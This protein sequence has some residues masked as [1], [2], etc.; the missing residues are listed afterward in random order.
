MHTPKVSA[1]LIGFLAIVSIY[2]EANAQTPIRIENV[3]NTPENL[4]LSVNYR[5]RYETLNNRFRSGFTGSDQ[6]FLQRLL[7]AG[8][9]DFGG[10]YIGAELQDSRQQLADSG[11]PVG[12]DDVNTFELLKAYVGYRGDDVVLSGDNLDI[13]AGRVTLNISSRRLAARNRFRN[14]IN[15]FTGVQ[16]RWTAPGGGTLNSFYTLPVNRLP[17]DAESLLSND[18]QFDRER[19][20]QRFWGVHYTTPEFISELTAEFYVFGLQESDSNSLATRD[21]N[22]FTPGVRFYKSKSSGAIDFDFETTLQVGDAA[23]STAA[24]AERLNT[25]AH[26]HHVQLG[27][28]FENSWNTRV[29]VQ[30]D[31]AS[32]D[33]DPDDSRNGRFDTL[34]GARR[35]EFG[36]TGIFGA[37]ARSNINSPGARI[38]LAKGRW[39][40][41]IG[42]RAAYLASSRDA[43]TTAGLLD[44]TG[45]SGRFIGHQWETRVRYDVIRGNVQLEAGVAHLLEGEFLRT[46]PNASTDGDNFFT[47]SQISFSF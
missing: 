43:L 35:F 15:G 1:G 44:S 10:V 6:I 2:S 7:L 14:T 23:L 34:F 37:L 9:Y 22:L 27:Y 46:A 29:A 36:P 20:N 19:I 47:Y 24:D 12:T 41:L 38:E 17:N 28:T 8:E 13:A 33:R 21:R 3:L 31:F 16:V 26:F 45:A 18:V 4:S 5:V 11:T 30:Y 42:Y 25:I 40:A 32:G 39:Q